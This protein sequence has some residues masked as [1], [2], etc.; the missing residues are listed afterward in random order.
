MRLEHWFYTIP[1]RLRSLFR[2]GQVEQEFEEELQI[3]LAQRIEEGI[4]RGKTPEEAR[5]AARG[6]MEGI[7]PSS[8]N[9]GA[10][11]LAR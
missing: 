8:M 6:A 5:Y 3:H 10:P 2:R 4:A 11:I 1:L 9:H 7:E